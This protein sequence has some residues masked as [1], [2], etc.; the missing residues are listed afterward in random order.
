MAR[1]AIRTPRHIP[2]PKIIGEQSDLFGGPT[3]TH[4]ATPAP[5]R[6]GWQQQL[7]AWARSDTL[8]DRDD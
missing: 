7:M 8:G 3:I 1:N 2:A 4:E 6:K 5:L